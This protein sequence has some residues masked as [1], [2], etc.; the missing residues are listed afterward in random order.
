MSE[1][2]DVRDHGGG[3]PALELNPEPVREWQIRGVTG[4]VPVC[5]PQEVRYVS[6]GGRFVPYVRIRGPI[7]I[8]HQVPSHVSPAVVV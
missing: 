1:V 4:Y 6:Q 5:G 3:R 2:P 8:P 7:V